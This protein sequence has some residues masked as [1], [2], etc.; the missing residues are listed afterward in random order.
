[1]S[2]RVLAARGRGTQLLRYIHRHRNY[3]IMLLPCAAYFIIFH[4]VP[5]YGVVLSFKDFSFAKGI[6]GS[7]WSGFANFQYLFS[8]RDF[9][10]VFWNSLVINLLKMLFFFPAPIIFALLLNEIRSPGYK[11]TTQTLIYLPYF[12]S[13]VV[14]GGIL[15]NFLSPTWGVINELIKETGNKPIFFMAELKYFR[16][17]VV[18]SEVWK[19]SG[20]DSIIYLAAIS[21]INPELYEAA[22]MDG[23][24]RWKRMFR[25]T[26]PQL[27]NVI[28][29]M[30]LLRIGH[31]MHNGF[32]QI[33]ILQNYSNLPVSEVFET[34]TYKIGIL[35]G[36]ISLGT[37]TGLFTS[38]IGMVLLII[39]DR[40]AKL[41]GE[42]GL[43]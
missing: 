11:K 6:L 25:I 27:T 14:I 19:N 30:G 28:I 12:I 39:A 15:I 42:E 41:S 17:L 8:L 7:P 10:S 33:F 32:E 2:D 9:Y 5:M 4:Y 43:F 36:R 37:A 31:L 38:V 35:S 16:P 13:W 21:T 26:L 40:L 22:V 29:I 24:N 18:L 1:M 34:Y 20:W 3:Y 23:A